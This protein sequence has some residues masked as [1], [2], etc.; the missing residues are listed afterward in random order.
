MPKMQPP[1]MAVVISAEPKKSADNGRMPPPGMK[2]RPQTD[3]QGKVSPEDAKVYRAGQN[4]INCT[5]YEPVNGECSKVAG[6]LDPQDG[7]LEYFDPIGGDEPDE[8]D[9][10]GESDNDE[11]DQQ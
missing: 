2:D 8:D 1:G 10:G 4:C 11:D 9:M 6:N 3:E 7:C 5:M